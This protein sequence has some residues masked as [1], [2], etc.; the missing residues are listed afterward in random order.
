MLIDISNG[1]YANMPASITAAF[2]GTATIVISLVGVN[3]DANL[4]RSG[5]GTK[6][7]F[8]SVG[9]NFNIIFMLIFCYSVL[10]ERFSLLLSSS[11]YKKSVHNLNNFLLFTS[12][13]LYIS[14]K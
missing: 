12:F 13:S 6:S 2:F 14:R 11:S 3:T 4:V 7:A 1:F 10:A 5:F 8:P 9:G